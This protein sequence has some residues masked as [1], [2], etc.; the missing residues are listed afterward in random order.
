MKYSFLLFVL[1]GNFVFSQT[2]IDSIPRITFEI[3]SSVNVSDIRD[4]DFTK[5]TTPNDVV[6]IIATEPL[7]NNEQW[8]KMQSGEAQLFRFGEPVSL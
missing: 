1:I 4:I 7:T 3:N 8:H 5:E 2:E 6:T